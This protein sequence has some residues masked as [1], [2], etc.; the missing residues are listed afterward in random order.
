MEVNGQ[1]HAPVALPSK[2]SH[3]TPNGQKLAFMQI[4]LAPPGIEPKQSSP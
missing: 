1:V 2:N 4:V 3:P